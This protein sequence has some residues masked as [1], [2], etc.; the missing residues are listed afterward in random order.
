[1]RFQP[2]YYKI[3]SAYLDWYREKRLQDIAWILPH[4]CYSLIN[5]AAYTKGDLINLRFSFLLAQIDMKL[6]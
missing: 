6:I 3:K 2:I 1:M 4:I 5:I